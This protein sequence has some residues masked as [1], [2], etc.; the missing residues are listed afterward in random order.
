M[1][2]EAAPKYTV[3]SQ[4]ETTQMAP[5]GTFQ[6]G[7]RVTFRLATGQQGSVF[8]PDSQYTVQNVAEAIGKKAQLMESIGKLGQ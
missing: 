8:L 6:P 7:V 4:Q 3:V 1:A 2:Q 5:D